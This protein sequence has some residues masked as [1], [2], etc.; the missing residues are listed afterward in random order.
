[1]NV[2]AIAAFALVVVVFTAII[3]PLAAWMERAANRRRAK[4]MDRM[5]SEN[6]GP[7]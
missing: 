6:S 1:M 4:L 7:K 3:I 2:Y 5:R